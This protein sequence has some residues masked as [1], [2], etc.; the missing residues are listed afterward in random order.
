MICDAL[1]NSHLYE[2][3]HPLFA[4]ALRLL[5]EGTLLDLPDGRHEIEGSRLVA[6]PQ[7]YATRE[8]G[9]W[10]AHQSYIDIQFIREGVEAIGWAPISQLTLTEHYSSQTDVAFYSGAGSR[11]LLREGMFAIFFP[12]D[13]HM[14]CLRAG[15]AAEQV[16]KIVLKLAV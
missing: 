14:P 7:R 2:K 4:R 13:G 16:R 15:N 6:L 11:L 9:K 5:S 12:E 10:E 3:C 8:D 1:A